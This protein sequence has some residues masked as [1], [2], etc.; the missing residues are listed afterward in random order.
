MKRI[1]AAV[2]LLFSVIAA[3]GVR[4]AD[5]PLPPASAP[6]PPAVYPAYSALYDWR[7][8][9]VGLNGGYGFGTSSWGGDPNKT[10]GLTSTGNFRTRGFLAGGTIGGNFQAGAFVFGIEADLDWQSLKGSS[11]SAYCTGLS[12]GSGKPA[13]GL[14]C[15][16][17]SDWVGTTRGRVGYAIDRALFFVTGGAAVADI[18]TGLTNQSLQKTAGQF[19]WT[20]GG[21]IEIGLADM[22]TAKVEYLYIDFNN[23]SCNVTPA[24]GFNAKAFPN[25][26]V[27]LSE[28]VVRAGINFKFT[29]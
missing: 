2:V 4:A 13:A 5:M 28:S 20:V 1:T 17:Q 12:T 6:A 23:A 26:T 18:L 16:T 14:S 10:S 24:C 27:K 19:G 3:D 22:W 21:G 15:Q 9:Y 11:S 7:G 8:F 25:D 29:P